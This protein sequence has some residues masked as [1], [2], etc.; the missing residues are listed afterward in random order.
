MKNYSFDKVREAL[1]NK[2][3]APD[4]SFGNEM[5]GFMTT[6]T[7]E[8]DTGGFVIANVEEFEGEVTIDG[9]RPTTW[10]N[11]FYL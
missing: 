8:S 11:E 10:Y 1:E 2:G 9:K 4:G 6:F 5:D 3:F 7:K